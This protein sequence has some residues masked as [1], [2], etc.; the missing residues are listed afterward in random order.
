VTEDA[1]RTPC[2]QFIGRELPK[3]VIFRH[4]D[5]FTGGVPDM[6]VSTGK[7]TSWWEFKL[8]DPK[9]YSAAPHVRHRGLQSVRMLQ[10]AVIGPAFYIVFA[11]DTQRRTLIVRPI[12]YHRAVTNR[13]PFETDLYAA[14]FNYRFVVDFIREQHQ[15]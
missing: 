14:G 3:A 13:R 1:V 10:L 8:L 11:D 12:D 6:S 9:R 15:L 5:K 4:E 2:V 7:L